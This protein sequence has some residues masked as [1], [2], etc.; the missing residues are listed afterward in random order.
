MT[1]EALLEQALQLPPEEREWLYE[2]VWQS[3]DHGDAEDEFPMSAE[4]EEELK[5]RIADFEATPDQGISWEEF[6][7][8]IFRERGLTL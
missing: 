1:M 3:L 8:E 2:R 4:Q 5:R 7:E 6:K